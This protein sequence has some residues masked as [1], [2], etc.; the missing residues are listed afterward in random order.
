MN[1]PFLKQEFS[2]KNRFPYPVLSD[3]RRD[4]IKQWGLELHNFTVLK[5]YTVPNRSIFV[6]DQQGIWGIFGFLRI[7]LL[8]QI[9]RNT[10]GS[11][12]NSIGNK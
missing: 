1:D 5:G 2:E 12:V 7:L 3:Y 11:R 9:R 8:N 10:E 4:V 6:L